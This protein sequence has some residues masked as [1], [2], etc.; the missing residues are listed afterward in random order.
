MDAAADELD[1]KRRELDAISEGDEYD[2]PGAADL[3]VV[4][5]TGGVAAATDSA[6]PVAVR[7]PPPASDRPRRSPLPAPAPPADLSAAPSSGL[8]VAAVPPVRSPL[9]RRQVPRFSTELRSV[10][11]SGTA[12]VLEEVEGFEVPRIREGLVLGF[13][14]LQSNGSL[15]RVVLP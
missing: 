1:Q 8:P 15:R 5:G 11:N 9:R 10:M 6:P 2:A 12:G 14:N 13:R 3:S 7:V 4:S